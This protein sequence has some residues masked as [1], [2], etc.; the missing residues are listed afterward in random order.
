MDGV[1]RPCDD[2]VSSTAANLVETPRNGH[3]NRQVVRVLCTDTIWE[4]EIGILHP[5]TPATG[6]WFFDDVAFTAKSYATIAILQ[7]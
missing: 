2:T 1:A 6:R 3:D 4:Y 7:L 5:S